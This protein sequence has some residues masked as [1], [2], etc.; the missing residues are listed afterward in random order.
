MGILTPDI[1]TPVLLARAMR[2]TPRSARVSD[3][4]FKHA[5]AVVSIIIV[6]P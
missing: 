2:G 1:L 4:P 5:S 6:Y 3:C